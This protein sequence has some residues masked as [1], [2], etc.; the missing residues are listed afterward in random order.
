MRTLAI[1][2]IHGC[3]QALDTLLDA[4]RLQP[5]DTLVTLGDY[6]DRGPQS[7]GVLERLI[8]LQNRCRLV[9]LKGNHDLMMLESRRDLGV[10]Q[11]WMACGGSETLASYDADPHWQLFADAIPTSHWRF[12]EEECRPSHTTNRHFFVHANADADHPLD[13]QPD[14]MLYWH[15]LSPNDSRPH[16]NGKIMICG[17]TS[18]RSGR[19]LDLG[20]AVCLD[21]WAYGSGWLTCLDVNTGL[22]WQANQRGETRTGWLDDIRRRSEA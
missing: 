4:I 1:G 15:R 20:H 8:R 12:L 9:P 2:D 19:P 11:D 16:E 10:F 5:A 6:V 13:D 7:A 3:L 22:Y 18:Q 14:H 17:H 21:T